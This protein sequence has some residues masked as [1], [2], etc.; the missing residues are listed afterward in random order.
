MVIQDRPDEERMLA[1][2]QAMTALARLIWERPYDPKLPARLSRVRCPALLLWGDDD[3]VVPLRYGEEY[4][5]HLPQAEWKVLPQC[6]HLPM[7]ERETEF[8]EAVAQFA[9]A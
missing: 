3:K 1:A 9:R 8:V 4:R 6:G 7:F 2:Y 5:K